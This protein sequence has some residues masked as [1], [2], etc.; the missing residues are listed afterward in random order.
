MV[1]Y[2][3]PL[4]INGTI[5]AVAWVFSFVGLPQ[6]EREKWNQRLKRILELIAGLWRLVTNP[7]DFLSTLGQ[8]E[9][10]D[11]EQPASPDT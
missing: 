3:T 11:G 2:K 6:D 8:M 10:L 9:A 7:K 4:L 1:A 5:F